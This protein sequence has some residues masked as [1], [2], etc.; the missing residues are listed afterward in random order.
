MIEEPIDPQCAGAASTV[1][2]DSVETMDIASAADPA[3]PH[4]ESYQTARKLSGRAAL[5]ERR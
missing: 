2:E 3:R 1:S 4:E 5:R